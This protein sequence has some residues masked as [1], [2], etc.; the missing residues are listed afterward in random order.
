M[1]EEA[2]NDARE[3]HDAFA[4]GDFV[5]ENGAKIRDLRIAYTTF[6]NLNPDKSNAILF[7]T[8]YSGTHTILEQAY[9]GRGRPLDPDRY[10]IIL[11]NQIGNGVSSSPTTVPPPYG[12]ARFPQPSIAD[13]V[14]AQ[15][16]LVT[17]A[18]GITRLALVLGGSMGAQQ[19]WEWAVR[20]PEAVARAAPIAGTAATTPHNQ[21][22]VDTF[23]EAITADPAYDDGWYAEGAV[24]RGLRRHA[25]LFAAAGFTPALFNR[26]LWRDHGF[27][28][29]DDF[30]TGFVEGHFLPQDPNNLLTLLRKWRSGDARPHGG[31]DLARALARVTAQ[32]SVIAIEEDG[33]FPLADI[34]AEQ[35]LVPHSRLVRVTS[36]WGHLA[37]FGLDPDY[38]R[39]VD[40]ALGALLSLPAPQ[41]VP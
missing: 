11:V 5:L 6:G 37:L 16:R 26:A 18:F 15:H 30:L 32:V 13:D 20:F 3:E 9:I 24:H 39:A 8:W 19:T 17:E 36:P 31:G 25:R 12:R 35:R 10:F 7:P 41:E 22:L 40:S 23:I 27:T 1:P 34:E 29:V 28:T 33:F 14:R 38:N 21:L 4:I 2:R